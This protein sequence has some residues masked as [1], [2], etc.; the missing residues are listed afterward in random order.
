MPLP[1]MISCPVVS[2][3][4]CGFVHL[5]EESLL[6]LPRC[7]VHHRHMVVRLCGGALVRLSVRFCISP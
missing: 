6:V 5:L 4:C 3:T 2:L 1:R 7:T